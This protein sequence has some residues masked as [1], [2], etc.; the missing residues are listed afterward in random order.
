M[1]TIE[2]PPAG[3]LRPVNSCLGEGQ[4]PPEPSVLPAEP[5]LSRRGPEAAPGAARFQPEEAG[6]ESAAG[7]LVRL[8]LTVLA[9]CFFF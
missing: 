8:V 3:L 4:Q 9:R 7:R 1:G 5:L 6:P 2:R